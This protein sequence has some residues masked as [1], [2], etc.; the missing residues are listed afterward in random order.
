MLSGWP[1]I[2]GSEPESSDGVFWWLV[3]LRW[4]A[5]LGV[6]L[7]LVLA[8]P[9]LGRLPPGSAPW[10]VTTAAGLL[11]Y[12]AA[13]G[14]LGPDRGWLTHLGG[15]IVVDCVSLAIFAHLA[16]G[17]D[18][19]FLPLFVLHVVNAN[20]VLS[21]RAALL[22]LGLAVSL[23]TA[24][25]VGEGTGLVAHHCLRQPGEPCPGGGLSLHA[26]AALGGLVL[27]FAASSLYT[28]S[29]M[30]TLRSGQRRLVATVGELTTEKQRLADTRAAIETERS[31]L[32]AIIDCMADAVIF[33]GAG[34][35]VLFANQ[36]A[37][38]LWRAGTEPG[39]QSFGALF[40]EV[41]DHPT[42]TARSGFERGG[43]S[44]EATH[45]LVRGPHGETL[46][47]VMVARDVT[48]RLEMERRLMH[49]EQ[50]SVVG[51]LAAAVAHEINN[52]IGVVC[53]YS[54]HALAKL[55]P[56]SPVYK[57][58]E[59]IHRNADGCRAIIGGLL[60]LARPRALER[61]RVDLRQLCRDAVDSVRLLATNAGVRISG[62]SLASDV[63][64]W[65]QADAGMLQQAVLNL[66]VNAIEAAREGDEV[67]VG[68]YETQDGDAS[69]RAIEVRD[70][71]PGIAADDVEH[72]FQPFFTTKAAGTGLGLS[73]AENIVRSHDGRIDVE[74]VVGAG[75]TFRI[76]L[77]DQVRRRP[78]EDPTRRT[79]DPRVAEVS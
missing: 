65:A 40:E 50:M 1:V 57:H 12:N 43:R 64:I 5:V 60:K 61:R 31:R 74:S 73:V 22:V 15:Q 30:G 28:R 11:A 34:G 68:A 70:T 3:R 33:V 71:G 9:V 72:V 24:V 52:P 10:L 47:L 16:G 66:A 23:V 63:P 6:A 20:I 76:V 36:R 38:E 79:P 56:E 41:E 78:A 32:Q 67:T 51:K 46:G 2:A 44:F 29:L 19:P 14:L 7:I 21:G 69:A 42:A 13:L 53:L 59:T 26:L 55:S 27:T 54:Q 75:T 18:N 37:R 62:G 39:L 35:H 48:D 77:P 17:I 49:D 25:V 4:V 58:I 8:G 45:S